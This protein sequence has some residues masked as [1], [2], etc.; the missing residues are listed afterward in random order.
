MSEKWCC[1]LHHKHVVHLSSIWVPERYTATGPISLMVVV[2]P[3]D[4][5]DDDSVDTHLIKLEVQHCQCG[6]ITDSSR[7]RPDNNSHY[8]ADRPKMTPHNQEMDSLASSL[9]KGSKGWMPEI[10]KNETKKLQRRPKYNPLHNNIPLESLSLADTP[11]ENKMNRTQ[12]SIADLQYVSDYCT[13]FNEQVK[14]CSSRTCLGYLAHPCM[15]RFYMQPS[16]QESDHEIPLSLA[17]LICQTSNDPLPQTFPRSLTMNLA[18]S[19]ADAVLQLYSTPWL[20]ERWESKDI[21]LF[22]IGSFNNNEDILKSRPLYFP[23]TFVKNS[24]GKETVGTSRKP[25]GLHVPSSSMA[26]I[27]DV[28]VRNERLFC[29]GIVLLELGYEK[30]WGILRIAEIKG[31]DANHISEYLVADRLAKKLVIRMGPNYVRIIRKC[32]ACDFGLGEANFDNEDLQKKF[33]EEVIEV[34]RG[35]G[36]GLEAFSVRYSI[37]PSNRPAFIR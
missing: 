35:V 10:P 8:D 3:Y 24:K 33:V 12:D 21:H 5:Y 13:H 32:I 31:L 29:L 20:P 34:L 25:L 22:G 4:G 37:P 14:C 23:L 16:Q 2:S 18:C 11:S 26:Q 36:D 17:D 19:I 6:N 15:D 30:P 9:Q 1:D 7:S 27:L 28:G